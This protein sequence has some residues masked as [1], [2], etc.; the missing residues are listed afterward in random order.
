MREAISGPVNEDMS[1]CRVG[2]GQVNS[3][4][5]TWGNDEG[6]GKT[7][8]DLRPQKA[9]CSSAPAVPLQE[10]K[11][12]AGVPS[13]AKSFRHFKVVGL[14]TRLE[15]NYVR[16]TGG[17]VANVDLPSNYTSFVYGGSI[18]ST[19]GT[20][21]RRWADLLHPHRLC[22]Y[23]QRCCHVSPCTPAKQKHRMFKR[24]NIT[25]E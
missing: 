17:R 11:A 13:M 8:S 15:L 25:R 4:A 2:G 6:E 1:S 19:S 18:K 20:T 24:T 10:I 12:L 9:K 7:A 16:L 5:H 22:V 23:S 21:K 14:G 3:L